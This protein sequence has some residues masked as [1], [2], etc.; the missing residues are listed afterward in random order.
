MSKHVQDIVLT[1]PPRCT[2]DAQE[3]QRARERVALL[4]SARDRRLFFELLNYLERGWKIILPL[5]VAANRAMR[6]ERT[7]ED[8]AAFIECDPVD[9]YRGIANT[10]MRAIPEA[11]QGSPEARFDLVADEAG[12]VA[13][14]LRI[15]A[16]GADHPHFPPGLR[17]LVR[18]AAAEMTE[19]RA[20]LTEVL[21]PAEECACSRERS[22]PSVTPSRAVRERVGSGGRAVL[23][24]TRNPGP[25]EPGVRAR[26]TPPA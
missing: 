3:W 6:G 9:V 4:E 26:A 25:P 2:F 12:D 23:S 16:L 18:S 5:H 19:W 24:L 7:A 17:E 20:G 11:P 13:R 14:Y 21:E 15:L 1:D 8:V 22:E 10:C